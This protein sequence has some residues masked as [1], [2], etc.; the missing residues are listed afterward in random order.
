MLSC[1]E[2]NEGGNNSGESNFHPDGEINSYGYV[3]LGLPS[4]LKWA[5]C[6]VGADSHEDYGDYFSWGD[7]EPKMDYSPENTNTWGEHVLLDIS[8]IEQYDAATANWG[9]AW[10]MP[11]EKEMYELLNECTWRWVTEKNVNGYKVEGPNGHSI[12]L[13]AAGYMTGDNHCDAG[14]IGRYW[15]SK[16]N[17]NYSDGADGAYYVLL[18]AYSVPSVN[19]HYRYNGQ[20]IRP[21]SD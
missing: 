4:G 18:D 9:E 13:P 5:T 14:S 15:I 17:N 8:G 1:K 11:K 2:R 12:F 7:T 16:P 20:N 21:V 19:C 3:D 10:R 6:N